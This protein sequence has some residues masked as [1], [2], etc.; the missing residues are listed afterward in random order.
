MAQ[1]VFGVCALPWGQLVSFDALIMPVAAMPKAYPTRRR[2]TAS[3]PCRRVAK[4]F[5]V[6]LS[7]CGPCCNSSCTLSKSSHLVNG[8]ERGASPTEVQKTRLEHFIKSLSLGDRENIPAL[9]LENIYVWYAELLFTSAR[10]L[11]D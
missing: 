11:Y 10:Q 1:V 3:L 2:F 7:G 6:C 9:A 4:S 8:G 5:H